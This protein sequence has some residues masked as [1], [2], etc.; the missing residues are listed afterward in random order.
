[1]RRLALTPAAGVRAHPAG[2]L[3]I[4]AGALWNGMVLPLVNMSI[5]GP[6]GIKAKTTCSSA[7][8]RDA[9]LVTRQPVA[10]FV[11]TLATAAS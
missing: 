3:D 5:R 4:D 2:P 7:G 10:P 6:F 1:M 11:T 8:R 9:A